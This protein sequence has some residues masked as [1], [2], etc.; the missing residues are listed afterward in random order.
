MRPTVVDLFAGAGGFTEG[1]KAAGYE[2][3]AAAEADERMARVYAT[4]HP[5]VVLFSPLADSPATGDVTRLRGTEIRDS[6]PANRQSISVVVGGPPC[7]GFSYIGKRLETDPRN[8]LY[9][10]FIRGVRELEPRA[11]VFENVLGFASMYG[12][13][14]LKRLESGLMRAGYTVVLRALEAADFGV[15]QFRQRLFAVASADGLVFDFDELVA[16]HTTTRVSVDEAIRDLPEAPPPAPGLPPTIVETPYEAFRPSPYGLRIRDG[17]IGVT[18]C[19]ISQHHPDFVRR[20]WL[21]PPNGRDDAT[22]CRRLAADEPAWT[23]RAGSPGRTACRPIHPRKPRV[24]T[25]REAARLSSFR[26]TYIF[27]Q[28]I[29]RA[30]IQIGNAV[31]PLMASALAESISEQLL[32]IKLDLSARERYAA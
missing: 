13:R 30:H 1:F 28:A 21:L 19:N 20:V 23:I 32:G 11:A 22:R 29:S 17:A 27:G 16:R 26:D 9:R 7:Q 5:E 4:N 6:L 2:V 14:F 12:G 18:H 10:A 3:L 31:P 24:I 15:P 25:A 8:D